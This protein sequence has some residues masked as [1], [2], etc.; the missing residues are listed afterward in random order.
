MCIF[1]LS[2]IMSI[3][4]CGYPVRLVWLVFVYL[5]S[6]HHVLVSENPESMWEQQLFPNTYLTVKDVTIFIYS[7]QISCITN[8]NC[9]MISCFFVQHY[10][11]YCL[12]TL[13]GLLSQ[14]KDIKITHSFIHMCIIF[15]MWTRLYV[16]VSLFLCQYCQFDKYLDTKLTMEISTLVES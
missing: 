13:A 4:S 9:T 6:W 3:I 16:I 2:F 8:Y 7:I 11:F 15:T 5:S 14:G 10:L 1:R 12:M